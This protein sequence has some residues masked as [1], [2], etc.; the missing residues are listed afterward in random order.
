MGE[1]QRGKAG[2]RPAIAGRQPALL[3]RAAIL[4]SRPSSPSP[5]GSRPFG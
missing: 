4:R 3:A 1:L 2:H 5:C